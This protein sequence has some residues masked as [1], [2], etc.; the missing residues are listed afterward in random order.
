MIE[1]SPFVFALMCLLWAVS[2]VIS[3]YLGYVAR[4]VDSSCDRSQ[5]SSKHTLQA[6][7]VTSA[8]SPPTV[9]RTRRVRD[10]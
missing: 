1:I 2:I 8:Q 6:M 3:F 5:S 7:D 4:K 9:S 10:A